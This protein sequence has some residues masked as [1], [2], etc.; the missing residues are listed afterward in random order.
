MSGSA[1]RPVAAL[2]LL[3]ASGS[4][5]AFDA[6]P[7]DGACEYGRTIER[8]L[9]SFA[10]RVVASGGYEQEAG[11]PVKVQV[12]QNDQR[13]WVITEAFL[14]QNRTCVVRSGIRLHML[15]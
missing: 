7:A 10:Y 14:K 12:W 5:S 15:Y 4:A 8:A 2:A 3:V 9:G 11:R 13:D 1:L 6:P